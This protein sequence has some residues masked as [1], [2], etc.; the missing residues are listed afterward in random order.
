M[1][2]NASLKLPGIKLGNASTEEIVIIFD[3]QEKVFP[4]GEV[5]ELE[6]HS[7]FP[8]TPG[9]A[10]L[11]KE[12]P[13]LDAFGRPVPSTAS[14]VPKAGAGSVDVATFCLE[15]GTALGLYHVTGDPEVDKASYATAQALGRQTRTEQAEKTMGDW[16]QTCRAAAS[17]GLL[18]P[19][20]PLHVAKADKF[21]IDNP[22]GSKEAVK[23]F[24]IKL[25]GA[26]YD[27]IEEAKLHIFRRPHYVEHRDKWKDQVVDRFGD[28]VIAPNPNTES[29]KPKPE[30][31]QEDEKPKKAKK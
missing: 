27:T 7:D 20:M 5:V 23:R 19:P 21:L 6:G 4:P 26:S 14:A 31:E 18:I 10:I 3:S 16:R 13:G 12:S 8:R 1:S 29:E 30:P 24:Q 11:K 25:D 15:R 9:G 28:D 17:A 2:L 22:R